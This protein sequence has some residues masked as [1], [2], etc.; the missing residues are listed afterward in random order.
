M[1][2]E[3]SCRHDV[4]KYGVKGD[5]VELN[6]AALQSLI[7]RCGRDG[8]GTLYFPAGQYL[9]GGLILRSRVNLLLDA[10][11][12]LLGSPRLE[13][14]FHYNPSPVPFPEGYE[15]VRALISA[16]DC[17]EI[18]IEGEGTI[19][20]QGAAFE[21][22][23]SVRG[24]RPRNLW[25]ARCRGI[26]VAGIHLRNSGFWM[27]HY[28]CCSNVR[29]SGLN[30][31]NHGGTNND[32]IDIDGCRDVVI[33]GC[34]VDSSDDAICLK[35]GNATPTENVVVRNCMTR[36]HCNHFKI[37]T[38]SRGGFH[39]IRVDGL[40]MT[41]SAVRE[42]HAGTEGADWRGACG[43]ALG[44]VDGGSLFDVA[45]SNV[46]MQEVRVPFF[47][48]LGDRAFCPPGVEKAAETAFARNIQL[49]EIR[50]SQAGPVGGHIIGLKESPIRDVVIE[51]S[52]FEYEGWNVQE[53]QFQ[54][55]PER[56]H[57]YPSFDAFGKLPA[58][59]VYLRD[60]VG[61]R[62]SGVEFRKLCLDPRPALRWQAARNIRMENVTDSQTAQISIEKSD[63]KSPDAQADLD[64]SRL[65]AHHK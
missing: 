15:G 44:A 12:S 10:G 37:G 48:R 45:V 1:N 9:T 19:D 63:R 38:E 3:L 8:G 22:C 11:S 18:A 17:E 57:A 24:G 41:P 26:R 25:F 16:L 32:G 14:Y 56:R 6:T 53:Y 4:A 42:S 50:A 60:V 2:V 33:E 36:S 5:G 52:S 30:V 35:S 46:T 13:D 59:G 64:T 47:I 55:V 28:L 65:E 27:Q 43:I 40:V 23:P 61:V 51:N 58:Y 31:W 62:F 39:H 49:S 54:E 7:D 34:R 20:G 29:L 21:S